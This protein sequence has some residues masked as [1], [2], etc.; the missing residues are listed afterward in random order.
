MLQQDYLT[1]QLPRNELV[2]MP[3]S[4][5]N[6]LHE[7]RQLK[8]WHSE[9]GGIFLGKY[10]GNYIEITDIT[11]PQCS[12]ISGRFFF[13][14]CSPKHQKTAYEQWQ[15]SNSE[16]T[17][18]GEWHTHPEQTPTPSNQDLNEWQSKLADSIESM[19]LCIIGQSTDWFGC[20]QSGGVL[21]AKE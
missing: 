5:L 7:H 10:R 21:E 9:K 14:R 3:I 6:K 4:I 8:F 12:D 19:F 2:I 1:I 13:N 17:Y 20:Y 11:L 18:V 15:N 16:I